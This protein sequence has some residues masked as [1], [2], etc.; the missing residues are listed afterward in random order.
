MLEVCPLAGRVH[1]V[2]VYALRPAPLRMNRPLFSPSS[3][4]PVRR[5]R[6]EIRPPRG[7]ADAL[8]ASTFPENNLSSPTPLVLPSQELDTARST[9][10]QKLRVSSLECADAQKT[11]G[12]VGA[13]T[14]LGTS[15]FRTGNLRK[16]GV[17]A[18]RIPKPYGIRT[19]EARTQSLLDSALTERRGCT[20][21][22]GF[23][24]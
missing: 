21:G 17:R 7:R 10:T 16:S 14:R 2:G 13:W 22:D 23:L 9:P 8:Q 3:G 20:S 24:S 4:V 6:L 5:P 15:L 19:Y 18:R 11:G 12:G 1:A